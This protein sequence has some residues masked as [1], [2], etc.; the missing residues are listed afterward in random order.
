MLFLLPWM[1]FTYLLDIADSLL[2]TKVLGLEPVG[3]GANPQTIIKYSLAVAGTVLIIWL[4][5]KL[6]DKESFWSLGLGWKQFSDDAWIGFLTAPALLGVGTLIL[7]AFSYLQ[8]SVVN[9]DP[10]QLTLQ[11]V[12]IILI[13]FAEEIV[14]RGYLL[15]NLLQSFNKWIALAISAAFFAVMHLANPDAT[16]LSITNILAAGFLLGINYI[17]TKNLWFGILFH[18]AWNFFQGPLYGYQV[19]G[20]KFTGLF[21][22]SLNGPVIW[23]GGPFGFEASLLCPL[24]LLIA[25]AIFAWYFSRRYTAKS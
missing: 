20:I 17:Y 2:A 5:R 21:Q 16:I 11:V 14:I 9:F 18:F 12:L 25:T 7:V 6:V 10:L 24:L 3:M 15:N 4:W 13:A 23:T 1:G 8:Y 19:S 22:Q